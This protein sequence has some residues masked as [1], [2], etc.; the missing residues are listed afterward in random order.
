MLQHDEKLNKSKI[1]ILDLISFLAGFAQASVVYVLSTYFKLSSGIENVG[2]FYLVAYA[3]ILIIFLNLHKIVRKIGKSDILYFSLF[4]KISVIVGLLFVSPGIGGIILAMGYIISGSLEWV[5]LDMILE[6]YS[7]DRMSGRIRGK[8]LTVMNTGIL[9]GPF[10]STVI[11]EKY[12]YYGI[13]LFLLI[14]NVVISAV[15]IW[16]LRNVNHRFH[17]RLTIKDVFEKVRKRKNILRIFHISFVLDFFYAL[18]II[19]TPIY[20]I[21]LGLSW[22]QVGIIL[23]FMLLP[24]IFLQYPVG[25]LADKKIGEKEMLNVAIILMGFSTLVIYFISSNN[26]AVWSVVLFS[27]RI[28]AALIEILRDSYFYKRIDGHDVDLID[29]FRMSRPLAYISATGASIPLLLF[30]PLK[31]VFILIA[32][33][34][35]SALWSAIHLADNKSEKEINSV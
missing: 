25:I 27:T 33:V 13:F 32:L 17:S 12:G 16:G 24:F 4:L 21:N 30:F 3:L 6:S 34:I 19:Y 5:S 11:L 8:Y 31:T 7:S 18:I 22:H 26:V 23:T 29:I 14:I 15:G 20:L 10:L 2:I 9:L 28:G 35:F 1:R